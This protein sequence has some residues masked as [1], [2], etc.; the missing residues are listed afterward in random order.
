[1]QT[2]FAAS[3]IRTPS[4]TLN[5]MMQS[6]ASKG[7]IGLMVEDPRIYNDIA[8]NNIWLC[9]TFNDYNHD[10]IPDDKQ[11]LELDNKNNKMPSNAYTTI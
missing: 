6:A 3:S 2:M 5:N 9:D 11:M 7:K 4:N 1:M 10:G 8:T